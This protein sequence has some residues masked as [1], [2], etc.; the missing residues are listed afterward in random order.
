MTLKHIEDH[1]LEQA[2][3][4][5]AAIMDAARRTSGEIVS[6]A[7]RKADEEYAA[8][9]ARVKEELK[10]ESDRVLAARQA[11]C[12]MELLKLKSR[13]LDDIFAGAREKLL[14]SDA[15]RR[16]VRE[17]LRS[18]AGEA[19]Q[20]LC[21]VEDRKTIAAMLSEL[22]REP[23]RKLPDLA[24]EPA[25]IAGGFILRGDAFDLDFSLD[26]QLEALRTEVRPELIAEA[27]PEG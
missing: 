10:T 26:S 8:A 4:E 18:L 22:G 14:A 1:I 19:G 27:F 12:R 24:E 7:R 21:R 9:I 5:A 20:I 6:A 11:E 2:K 17:Q 15:Y 16:L 3:A 23:S 25:D 13:I